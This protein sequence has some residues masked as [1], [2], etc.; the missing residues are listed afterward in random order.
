MKELLSL[1]M[2]KGGVSG[3]SEDSFETHDDMVRES[4]KETASARQVGG[5]HYK[6]CVIQPTEYIVKNKLDFLEGNVVKYITRHKTKGQEEDIRKVIHY[7]ELILE[8]VYDKWK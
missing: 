7:C 2:M 1:F 5:S 3:M 8:H 6:D 4:V